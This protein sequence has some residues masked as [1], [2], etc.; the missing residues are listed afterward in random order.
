MREWDKDTSSGKWREIIDSAKSVQAFGA[1][2][3]RDIGHPFNYR[4]NYFSLFIISVISAPLIA[5]R[6]TVFSSG[7]TSLK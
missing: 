6:F 2:E 3:Y 5:G 7:N 4:N 1:S